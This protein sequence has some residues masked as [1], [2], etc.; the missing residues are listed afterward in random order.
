MVI[1]LSADVEM[2][3]L[4][5]GALSALLMLPLLLLPGAA[6]TPPFNAG[7]LGPVTP[8]LAPAPAAAALLLVMLRPCWF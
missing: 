6:D 5:V 3:S 4:V 8:V 1:L 7:L 2:V